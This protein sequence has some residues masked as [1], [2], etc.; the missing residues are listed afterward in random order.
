ME[1]TIAKIPKGLKLYRYH[2]ESLVRGYLDRGCRTFSED[3]VKDFVE[4]G[5]MDA[6]T[7]WSKVKI[8]VGISDTACIYKVDC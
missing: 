1:E 3:E 6:T 4:H 5:R 2:I 8:E 7:D